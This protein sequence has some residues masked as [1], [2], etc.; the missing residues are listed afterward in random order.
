M[1]LMSKNVKLKKKRVKDR[2]WEWERNNFN[3]DKMLKFVRGSP[4]KYNNVETR[5]IY[6]GNFNQIIRNTK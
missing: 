3:R 1:R 6:D 5:W 2:E 4:L